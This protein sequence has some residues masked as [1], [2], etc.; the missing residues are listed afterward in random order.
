MKIIKV[1]RNPRGRSR[2]AQIDEPSKAT[3]RQLLR[4]ELHG[5]AMVETLLF[6]LM[7]IVSVWPLMAAADAV[8]RYL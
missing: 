3:L 4:D 5:Q 1:M 8:I 7:T 2:A 6:I